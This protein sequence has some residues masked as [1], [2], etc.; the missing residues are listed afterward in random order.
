M[1]LRAV[2]CGISCTNRLTL[3]YSILDQPAVPCQSATCL[4][5][6]WPFSTVLQGVPSCNRRILFVLLVVWQGVFLISVWI[7]Q[8]FGSTTNRCGIALT[9][10]AKCEN[11]QTS[12]LCKSCPDAPECAWNNLKATWYFLRERCQQMPSRLRIT[13]THIYQLSFR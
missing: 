13:R 11:S 8:G 1:C 12:M 2:C 6:Y 7:P 3:V 5:C 4:S 10:T 9:T